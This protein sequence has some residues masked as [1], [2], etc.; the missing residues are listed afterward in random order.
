VFT[1]WLTTIYNSRFRGSDTL[2]WLLRAPDKTF[3]H[4]NI[5]KTTTTKQNSFDMEGVVEHI[6]NPSTQEIPSQTG[7]L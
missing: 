3:I 5:K 2:F 6:F 4:I 7:C 1:W